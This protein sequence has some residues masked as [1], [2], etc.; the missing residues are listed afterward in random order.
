MSIMS[1]FEEHEAKPEEHCQM[2]EV[3]GEGL[4]MAEV[5]DREPEKEKRG[6]ITSKSK[7]PGD[8]FV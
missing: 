8:Q 4:S 5:L 2:E 6:N 7:R 1:T 3:E